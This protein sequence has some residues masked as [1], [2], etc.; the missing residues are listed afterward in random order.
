MMRLGAS[1]RAPIDER[2]A[3]AL[4]NAQ[5]ESFGEEH[6]HGAKS[7]MAVMVTSTAARRSRTV[8]GSRR[9]LQNCRVVAANGKNTGSM[10][11]SIISRFDLPVAQYGDPVGTAFDF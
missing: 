6:E 2:F 8:C 10:H 11:G 5:P 3:A 1:I 7:P 4:P 9:R